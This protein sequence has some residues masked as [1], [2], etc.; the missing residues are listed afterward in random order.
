MWRLG[1]CERWVWLEWE[2]V[3]VVELEID[4]LIDCGVDERV[5]LVGALVVGF[6]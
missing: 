4:R 3:G 2:C 6:M 5:L 1:H